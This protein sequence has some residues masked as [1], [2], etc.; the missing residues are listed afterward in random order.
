[1]SHWLLVLLLGL[2]AHF[3]ASYI[4]PLDQAGQGA[5]GGLLRWFWP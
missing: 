3:A 5:F 1:M 4:V 2:D